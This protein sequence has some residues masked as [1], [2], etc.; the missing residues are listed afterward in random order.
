VAAELLAPARL[1]PAQRHVADPAVE[2]LHR[3]PREILPLPVLIPKQLGLGFDITGQ[4][5]CA[6]DLNKPFR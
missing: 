6:L 4:Q 1:Q 5:L 3:A 2:Q